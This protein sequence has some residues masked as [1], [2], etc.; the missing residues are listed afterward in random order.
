MSSQDSIVEEIRE[1]QKKVFATMSFKEKLAYFWDYYKIH[2]IAAVL[3][4]AF[5]IAFISSYRSNKPFAFY[6]V[7]L[8]AASTEEN[9]DTS[10]IW[11]DE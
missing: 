1:E 2:T 10:V 5:V 3:V 9:H 7:L 6:A 8:N 11:A 4:I